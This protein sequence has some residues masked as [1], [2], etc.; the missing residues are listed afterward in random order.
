MV[1]KFLSI[2][3][4]L[5]CGL[6]GCNNAK[7]TAS[8]VKG[9][10]V[11]TEESRKSLPVP[12]RSATGRIVVDEKG[13]FDAVQIPGELLWPELEGD[14]K[15]VTGSGVWVVDYGDGNQQLRL[16]FRKISGEKDRTFDTSL[17]FSD[18]RPPTV[19]FYFRGDPDEGFRM[20]FKKIR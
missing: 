9:T 8:D 11:L 18:D 14:A 1:S 6:V 4:L 13:N 2:A 20:E 16:G 19:I 12:L 3:F 17:F 15:L 5:V 10:W 7:L